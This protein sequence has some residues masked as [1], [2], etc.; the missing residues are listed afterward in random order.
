MRWT[1]WNVAVVIP[2]M[3]SDKGPW[4]K[5]SLLNN[6]QVCS[7][8][9]FLDYTKELSVILISRIYLFHFINC[10]L[11]LISTIIELLLELW[12]FLLLFYLTIYVLAL[13]HILFRMICRKLLILNNGLKKIFKLQFSQQIFVLL[14][15]L[16]IE[17]SYMVS[18]CIHISGE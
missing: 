13:L 1:I 15:W 7:G 11:L 3:F 6:S 12:I 9:Y 16:F 2:N 14:D 4:F 10:R 5:V 18:I 8:L 17:S